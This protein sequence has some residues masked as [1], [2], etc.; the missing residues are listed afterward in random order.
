MTRVLWR[1]LLL[2]PLLVAC[3]GP[4]TSRSPQS[5]TDAQTEAACRQRA[6]EIYD[7]RHRGDIY[8]PTPEINAPSSGSYAPGAPDRGLSQLYEHDNLINDCIRNTG[9]ETD[10]GPGQSPP[11]LLSEP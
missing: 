6:E 11:G 3:G 2:L 4:L 5:R 1:P 8:S 9:T 10:R 7:R